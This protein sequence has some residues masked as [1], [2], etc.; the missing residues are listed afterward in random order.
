MNAQHAALAITRILPGW[1]SSLALAVLFVLVWISPAWFGWEAVSSLRTVVY[2]EVA[3]V[4]G[5]LFMTAGHDEPFAWL[6]ILPVAA[7]VGV[8]LW[9]VAG[10][11]AAIV[12]PLHLMV[13]VAG[14]WSDVRTVGDTSK[15]LGIGLLTMLLC[16]LTLGLL[17]FPELGW[18]AEST[19][20]QLWWEVPSWTGSR[21]IPFGLPAWGFL[22]FLATAIAD[23]IRHLIQ[24][25]HRLAPKSTVRAS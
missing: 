2:V 9:N 13:R 4:Y 22:Y 5:L 3:A 6:P 10:A 21:R 15:A 20:Q 19:P 12:L 11:F 14:I 17:P 16:W 23:A 8:G 7:L 18:T 24:V 25:M 1:V